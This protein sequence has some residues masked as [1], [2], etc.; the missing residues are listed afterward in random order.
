MGAKQETG[1]RES[2]LEAL[3]KF[4]QIFSSAQQ[5]FRRIED[6]CGLSGAQLWALREVAGHP[7]RRVSDLAKAMSVHLSTAS[8]LLDKL[9]KRNLV[10]RERNDPDQRIVRLFLTDEGMRIVASAPGPARGVLPE[11]LN[12]LPEEVLDD[13]NRSLARLLDTIE[14][15]DKDAAMKPLSDLVPAGST[16]NE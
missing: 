10:R 5:H 13:L 1:M 3:K 12:R 7:G 8:N 11:A 4:R 14:G 6:Q 9:S 16:H 15:G 2:S